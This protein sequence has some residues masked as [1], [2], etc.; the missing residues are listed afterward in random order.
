[1]GERIKC[2]GGSHSIFFWLPI[3][4]GLCTVPMVLPIEF[5]IGIES[6]I[7]LISLILM[8][9]TKIIVTD[10]RVVVTRGFVITKTI[11][12]NIN[13]IESSEIDWPILGKILNYGTII[14]CCSGG[15]IEYLKNIADPQRIQEKLVVY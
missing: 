15:R 5:T 2:T 6:I 7:V 12:L 14:I 3:L 4:L 8:E 1:M 10:K 11:Q 9:S 13:Q